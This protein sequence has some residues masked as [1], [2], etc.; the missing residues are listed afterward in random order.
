MIFKFLAQIFLFLDITSGYKYPY[1]KETDG[2]HD[3]VDLTIYHPKY[4]GK[5]DQHDPIDLAHFYCTISSVIID[6][7]DDDDD[8]CLNDK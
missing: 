7:D 8:D 5:Y 4:G 3:Y 6:D 2:F 1:Q